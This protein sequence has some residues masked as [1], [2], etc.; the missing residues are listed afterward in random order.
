VG[1]DWGR[2]ERL[3]GAVP[4]YIRDECGDMVVGRFGMSGGLGCLWLGNM[5]GGE[6]KNGLGRCL[7]WEVGLLQVFK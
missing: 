1:T 7:A 5:D 3:E 2:S 4:F 6:D